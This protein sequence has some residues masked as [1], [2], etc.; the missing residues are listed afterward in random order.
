MALT[1]DSVIRA[2]NLQREAQA[3]HWWYMTPV[4]AAMTPFLPAPLLAGFGVLRGI[5]VATSGDA[6]DE[7]AAP[8]PLDRRYTYKPPEPNEIAK[9]VYL[10]HALP[11]QD[12]KAEKERLR[13]QHGRLSEAMEDEFNREMVKRMSPFFL[14][15]DLLTRHQAVVGPTGSGKT[16]S[17]ALTQASAQI[18]LR[19]GGL[20]FFD[21]K[22]DQELVRQIYTMA[23]DAG[24]EHDFMLLDT[25]HP[26]LSHTYNPLLRGS[27]DEVISIAMRLRPPSKKGGGSEEFF[28]GM[29]R[30]AIAAAV[31]ALKAQEPF[32]PFNFADLAVLFGEPDRFI[33]L[34][35]MIPEHK[36]KEKQFVYSFLVQWLSK[37]RDGEW[38]IEYGKYREILAG[39]RSLCLDFCHDH[40]LDLVNSYTPEIELKEAITQNKIVVISIPALSNPAGLAVFGRLFFA[41]L[42]RAVGEINGEGSQPLVPSLV[43]LDEH[44]MYFDPEAQIPLFIQARSAK[45][46]LCSLVQSKSFLDEQSKESAAQLVANCWHKII[47]GTQEAGD[48]EAFMKMAPTVMTQLATDS[49]SDNFSTSH[50]NYQPGTLRD[51][52]SGKS[53]SRGYREQREEL[54]QPEDF[55]LD[56]GESIM[57]GRFG[58]F[59]FQHPMLEIDDEDLVPLNEMKISRWNQPKVKGMNLMEASFRKGRSILESVGG[60]D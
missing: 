7:M 44:A 17:A 22:G 21:A 51:E 18:S 33:D 14:S 20:V 3:K 49:E 10:G 29:M 55:D 60:S 30:N 6:A 9:Q 12:Y 42:A 5:Q 47:F 43:F 1:S 57:V 38:F 26:E 56:Y 15:D 36:Q 50:K 54:L 46:G 39:A 2:R 48:R 40:W 41:D 58:V 37:N 11:F 32:K 25:Q 23:K 52:S 31:V 4:L 8:T 45:V 13:L 53:V 16:L 28:Q 19:G 24:R 34:Y 59:R 35:K 27:S